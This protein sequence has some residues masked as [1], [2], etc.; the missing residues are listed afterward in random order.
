MANEYDNAKFYQQLKETGEY[1]DWNKNLLYHESAQNHRTLKKIVYNFM[2]HK[3][4]ASCVYLY[5]KLNSFYNLNRNQ[6]LDLKRTKLKIYYI[7]STNTYIFINGK[8]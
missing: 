7:K 6:L 4:Y 2:K 5:D 1:E 3:S 8:K